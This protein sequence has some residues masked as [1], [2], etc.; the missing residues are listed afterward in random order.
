MCWFGMT[1]AVSFGGKTPVL[2]MWGEMCPRR[3]S[4]HVGACTKCLPFLQECIYLGQRFPVCVLTKARI[5]FARFIGFQHY[6][7]GLFILKP[8]DIIGVQ[9]P[10]AE[11]K[12]LSCW[13][14]LMLVGARGR[15]AKPAFSPA[16]FLFQLFSPSR[17]FPGLNS[18]ND[19]VPAVPNTPLLISYQVRTMVGFRRIGHQALDSVT[20]QC[21]GQRF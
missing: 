11:H 15:R 9:D 12:C 19:H 2:Q 18:S 4:S 6:C 10:S 3:L 13:P 14:I 7:P 21:G 16:P 1:H 17:S 20:S 8:T 5:P